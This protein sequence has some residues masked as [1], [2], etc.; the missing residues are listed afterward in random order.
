[1][2]FK[3]HMKFKDK[4]KI[5]LCLMINETSP[6]QVFLVARQVVSLKVVKGSRAL[7]VPEVEYLLQ[8]SKIVK[9]KKRNWN[10]LLTQYPKK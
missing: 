6:S 8:V 5:F 3:N 9:R 10:L 2:M 7:R 4:L 1:M